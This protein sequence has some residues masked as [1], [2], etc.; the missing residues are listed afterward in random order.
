MQNSVL[1][2]TVDDFE[3]KSADVFLTFNNDLTSQKVVLLIEGED[4]RIFYS[5]FIIEEN[6][7]LFVMDGHEW[8]SNVLNDLTFIFPNQLGAIKDAD[9]CHLDN[10]Y[11]AQDNLFITDCHDWEMTIVSQDR[12]SKIA[13]KYGINAI[14]ANTIHEE[15]LHEL[16]NYSYVRWANSHIPRIDD[17]VEFLKDAENMKGKTIAEVVTI[18]NGNQKDNRRIELEYVSNFMDQHIV[19]DPRQLHNGHDYMRM[20][21]KILSEKSKQNIKGGEIPNAYSQLYTGAD[22]S[23]T[24]LAQDLRSYNF[25]TEILL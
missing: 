6:V 4:D 14:E 20:L 7:Y 10:K 23:L 18:V 11:P 17:R 16:Q 22:F 21:R 19:A 24:K 1:D 12:T 3:G 9:F 13:A 5:N 8:M 25:V 15:V 2:Y